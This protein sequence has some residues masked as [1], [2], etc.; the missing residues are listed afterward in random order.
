M[1]HSLTQTDEE[2]RVA[3]IARGLL[4]SNAGKKSGKCDLARPANDS[5][6]PLEV[7]T[8]VA[9]VSVPSN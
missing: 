4:A 9:N 2:S 3:G 6:Q 1:R 7:N 8:S 5:S